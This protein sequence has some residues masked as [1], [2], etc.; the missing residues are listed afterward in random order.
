M[1]I[2]LKLPKSFRQLSKAQVKWIYRTISKNHELT[3]MELKTFAFIRFSGIKDVHFNSISSLWEIRLGKSTF[4]VDADQMAAAIRELDWILFPPARPWRPDSLAWGK[5]TDADFS[6]M[7]FATY[8]EIENLFQGYLSTTNPELLKKIGQR[9]VRRRLRGFRKYELLII[10]AWVESVREHFSTRLFRDLFQKV[11]SDTLAA[12]SP[13]PSAKQLKDA[14]DAQIRA[15]TKGDI[16]KESEILS[17]PCHRALTELCAQAQ[18]YRS[19]KES[20]KK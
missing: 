2:D 6:D 1:T 20:M 15:L 19:L 4:L 9:L 16:T 17:M 18:E 5:P 12:E 10:F 13:R 11:E 8:L 3:A 7:D 14:M